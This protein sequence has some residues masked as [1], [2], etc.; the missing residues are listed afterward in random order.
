M[1]YGRA[2]RPVKTRRR[3][4]HQATRSEVAMSAYAIAQIEVTNPEGFAAYGAAVPEIVARHGGRYLVRGGAVETLEGRWD[5]PR[6][7]IIAF[8][9]R[10]AA[11]RFYNSPEYQEILPLRLENSKGT[12]VIAEGLPD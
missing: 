5:V 9:D 2:R 11:E 8:P 1:T 3:V 10:A 7:V 6:L 4:I 12:F